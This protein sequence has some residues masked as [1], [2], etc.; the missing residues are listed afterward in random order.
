MTLKA[1]P[2][3]GLNFHYFLHADYTPTFLDLS[4]VS[5]TSYLFCLCH[6]FADAFPPLE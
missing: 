1:L 5:L 6:A 2:T 3:F 4:L